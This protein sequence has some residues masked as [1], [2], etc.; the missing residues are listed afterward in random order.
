MNELWELAKKLGLCFRCIKRG[1]QIARCSLK[2]T[3]PA[4]GCVQRHH[5]ELHAAIEL[6][7]LNSSADT[8]HVL[9]GAIGETSATGTPTNHTTCE[10]TK[11]AESIPRP[12]RVALQMI[13]VI[14]EGENGI[15]ENAFLDG[16]SGS[17]YLKKEIADILGLDAERKPLRVAVFGTTSIVTDSKTVTVCLESMDRSVKKRVFLWTTPK[18]CEMTAVDWSPNARKL[19]HLRDLEI[20]KPVEHGRVDVLI[21]SAYY[22]ELLLPLEHRI[23]NPG[24]P[25]G[26][27]TPLGWTIVGH[28]SETA[29]TCSIANC[30]YTFHTTFSPEMRADE[31]MRRMWDEEVVGITNQNKLLTA[32]EAEEVLAARKVAE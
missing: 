6:P 3:C 20:R 30:V 1:H 11:E 4:E 24:E 23:G 15:K 16:R 12:G 22:E 14:L 21:G 29:N 19:D 13:P 18:I 32:E 7:Q 31:L 8:S 17:S 27:K 10:V 26:V 2:G 25:V 28:V 9:Q 5:P